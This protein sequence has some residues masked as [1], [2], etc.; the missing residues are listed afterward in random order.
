MN[1]P[2]QRPQGAMIVASE[3]GV[4]IMASEQGVR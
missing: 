1:E 2:M 3:Q 4:P